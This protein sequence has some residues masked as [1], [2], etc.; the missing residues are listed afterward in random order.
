L[1]V[2]RIDNDGVSDPMG[3]SLRVPV[4]RSSTMDADTQ[5]RID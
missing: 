5:N 1:I 4:E 2:Y 3:Q